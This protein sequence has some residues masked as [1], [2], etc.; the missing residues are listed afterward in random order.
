MV[1]HLKIALDSCQCLW[2]KTRG[3]VTTLA[4]ISTHV[5]NIMANETFEKWKS[6]VECSTYKYTIQ[7]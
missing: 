6:Y 3:V 1:K 2:R 7:M 4:T 5:F